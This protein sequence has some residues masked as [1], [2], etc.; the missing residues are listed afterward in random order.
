M[1]TRMAALPDWSGRDWLL[2]GGLAVS[3]APAPVALA[4]VWLSAD[5]LA[6]G[7]LVP[8]ALML[9]VGADL[10]RTFGAR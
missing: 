1:S 8:C 4:R 3:F 9:A 7:F 5:H 10:R 6:H 2:A